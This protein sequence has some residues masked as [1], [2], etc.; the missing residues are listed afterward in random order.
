MYIYIRYYR[1]STS[2]E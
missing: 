1:E 2:G